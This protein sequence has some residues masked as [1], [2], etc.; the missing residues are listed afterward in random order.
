MTFFQKR[1]VSN[2]LTKL[3]ENNPDVDI[4][5]VL[6]HEDLSPTI[7]EESEILYKRILQK[8]EDDEAQW[9]HQIIN[10]ALFDKREPKKYRPQNKIKQ[11]NKNAANFLENCGR[12]FTNYFITRNNQKNKKDEFIIKPAVLQKYLQD[13]ITKF[14]SPKNK[15]N[16]D[17]M[18]AGHFQRFIENFL[19]W[20]AL[21]SDETIGNLISFLVKNCRILAYQQLI[22]RLI[23]DYNGAVENEVIYKLLTQMLYQSYLAVKYIRNAN[24]SDIDSALTTSRKNIRN[25]NLDDSN[26]PLNL[27]KEPIPLI[28]VIFERDSIYEDLT[29]EREDVKIPWKKKNLPKSINDVNKEYDNIEDAELD[30]Y[31]LIM[32]IR[33]SITEQTEVINFFREDTDEEYPLIQALFYCGTR[34]S[35]KSLI[36]L[37]AFRLL[38]IIFNGSIGLS[39]KPWNSTEEGKSSFDFY[40]EYANEMVFDPTCLTYKMIHALPVFWNHR[41]NIDEY[42]L[43]EEESSK[44]DTKDY[45][46]DDKKHTRERENGETALEI[47]QPCLFCEPPISSQLIYSCTDIFIQLS[48]TRRR[49]LKSKQMT[50][51]KR[52]Q[53][54]EIDGI[55]LD[56]Y[57]H[58][59]RFGRKYPK[60]TLPELVLKKVIV[61]LNPIDRFYQKDETNK[62]RA[63]LNGFITDFAI[64]MSN[65]RTNPFFLIGDEMSI[66]EMGHSKCFS[67]FNHCNF[68]EYKFFSNFKLFKN[69]TFYSIKDEYEENVGDDEDEIDEEQY[70]KFNFKIITDIF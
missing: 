7:R 64:R 65:M 49:I 2:K 24:I 15:Y 18:Y 23:S 11:I 30:A 70:Q 21:D 36:S 22:T 6:L 9:F 8:E 46:E 13:T 32:S 59:F 10:Y 3:I 37:E 31:L 45:Y 58:H 63:I 41:Y 1:V 28:G 35:E 42:E 66:T 57:Q 52:D 19:R 33:T 29:D 12:K 27:A 39:I 40:N 20:Q 68:L 44:V 50:K 54:V 16:K 4:E 34:C 69:S 56:F 17:P 60:T 43:S 25:Q 47:L 53:M 55:I 51:T 38:T 14:M 67:C 26:Q 62:R 5:E 61:P 48:R